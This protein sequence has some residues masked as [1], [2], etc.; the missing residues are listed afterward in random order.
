MQKQDQN[1]DTPEDSYCQWT[2]SPE[3]IL[4]LI[5][6]ILFGVLFGGEPDLMDSILNYIDS[7]AEVHK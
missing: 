6:I 7:K 5:A 4:I 3:N 2:G 1:Q